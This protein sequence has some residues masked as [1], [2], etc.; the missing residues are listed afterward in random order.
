MLPKANRLTKNQTIKDLAQKGKSF[1][2]P[3]FSIKYLAKDNKGGDSQFA[4]V[5]SAKVDKRAVVRNRLTRQ[6]REV[7]RSF[8]PNLSNG[9]FVLIIA[10]KKA[11]NLDFAK[12]REQFSFAF[13]KIK[14]YN[15]Q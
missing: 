7:V 6:M 5:V 4:F 15:S 10:K 14:I 1:F 3:E 12:I 8:L 13:K 11:L 2:L 9:Y